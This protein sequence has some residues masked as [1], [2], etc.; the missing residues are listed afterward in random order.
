MLIL[1]FF[2]LSMYKR[3]VYMI[4]VRHLNNNL[5]L[6]EP[7]SEIKQAKIRKNELKESFLFSKGLI[8]MFFIHLSYTLSV[9]I[10]S[11][12]IDKVIYT[13][14]Q[15]YAGLFI[16]FSAAATPIVYPL[17]HA[18]ICKGCQNVFRNIFCLS[19]K[20]IVV[21]QVIYIHRRLLKHDLFNSYYLNFSEAV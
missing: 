3:I 9:I 19:R 5:E 10:L 17:F 15:M 1:I 6:N 16:R 7:F 8:V 21:K 14:I 18:S 20:K 13:Y 2:Y 11:I 12:D 4:Q